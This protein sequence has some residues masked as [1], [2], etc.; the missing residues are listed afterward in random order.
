[1]PRKGSRTAVQEVA[2]GDNGARVQCHGEQ[3]KIEDRRTNLQKGI[4][5][6]GTRTGANCGVPTGCSSGLAHQRQNPT[7]VR[8]VHI[9]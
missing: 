8:Q 1:M 6:P 2:W 5:Q 7:R 9:P 4:H 3:T